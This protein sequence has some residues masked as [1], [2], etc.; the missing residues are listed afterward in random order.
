MTSEGRAE[1]AVALFSIA[2]AAWFL[3]EGSSLKPGVF[4]PIGPGAVPMG[5]AVVTIVLSTLVLLGRLKQPQASVEAER[6]ES[7]AWAQTLGVGGLTVVYCAALQSGVL[8]YGI[9][10]ALYLS[11]VIAVMAPQRRAALPWAVTIG[12]ATGLGLDAVFRY[13]L[14]ADLP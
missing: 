11:V 8:R 1:T 12:A 7:T 6:V 5:V 4:E 2:L 3:F 10:T 9:V 14:V 13:L